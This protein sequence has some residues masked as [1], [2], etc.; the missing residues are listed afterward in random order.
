MRQ[1]AQLQLNILQGKLDGMSASMSG[2]LK[3]GGDMGLAMKM[4]S[5]FTS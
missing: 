3:I 4:Q 1:S 2:K 5:H